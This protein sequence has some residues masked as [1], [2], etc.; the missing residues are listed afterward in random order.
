MKINLFI[1]PR[2]SKR[3][4][5]ERVSDSLLRRDIE[6]VLHFADLRDISR[7]LLSILFFRA[8]LEMQKARK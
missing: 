7:L 1:T 8:P 4:I 5:F 6:V 2:P 3:G